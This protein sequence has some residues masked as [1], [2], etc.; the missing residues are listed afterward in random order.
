MSTTVLIKK[1]AVSVKVPTS[2]QLSFGEMALNYADGALYYKNTNNNVTNLIQ[3]VTRTV[4]DFTATSGQTTFSVSYTVGYID[5]YR[6]GVR[7]ANGDYT[8]TNGTSIVL[9]AACYSG[10]IV[11]TVSY[12]NMNL[13]SQVM[14]GYT[15]ATLPVGIIGLRAY[16]TDAVSPTF[17]GTLTGGGSITT[18]VFYNGTAWVSG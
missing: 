4:T 8:A 1:S 17:L 5:V 3:T 9:S 11:E 13:T 18:P 7:L 16:V 12:T 2:G 14:S 15:V 10:D 6:N